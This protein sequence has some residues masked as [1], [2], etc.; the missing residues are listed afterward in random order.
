MDRTIL[1][2][3]PFH[4]LAPVHEPL[5]AAAVDVFRHVYRKNDFI[6]GEDV[7]HFEEEFSHLVGASYGVGMSSG[8]AALELALRAL[9][10]GPGDEV[11][12]TPFSFF[13][14][15][16][17]IVYVGARPIFV[18]IDPKT[19]NM[20]PLFLERALTSKT[21]AILPVH[22]FG[23]P[24]NMTAI[25]DIALARKIPVVEDAC[26]AHGARWHGR[27]VGALGQIGCFSFYPTKNL[28]GFGD[29]GMAVTNDGSLVERLRR[30][31]NCGRREQ[32]EHLELGYN[33]RL[34]NLQAALLRM[35]LPHLKMWTEDRQRL[36]ALYRRELAECSVSPLSVLSGADPVYHLFTVRTS[37]RDALR[38]YLGAQ[39][40]QTGIFYPTPLH[41][42][43]AFASL[44]GKT[45]DCPE[46]ER[47]STEC[48]SLPL[49]PGLSEK[50]VQ[51]VAA[52]VHAFAKG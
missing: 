1:E 51:R 3:I 19:L 25:N 6:L 30:L 36:A 50:N 14:T 42:Q 40:I 23:H 28:G 52:A 12:T 20:N 35:K 37:R 45:G 13:A 27:P 49:Y 24:A 2:P 46:A 31:R 39:G 26:Q 11:I 29:G 41:L 34:D 5:E 22:L 9:G 44:G 21:K 48:L 10:V 32:Y 43:P 7:R 16:A 17:A 15:A 38:E 18:D 8:T 4:N 33:E 47:A